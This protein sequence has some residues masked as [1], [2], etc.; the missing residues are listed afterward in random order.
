LSC[1]LQVLGLIFLIRV[2]LCLFK[3]IKTYFLSKNGVYL[4]SKYGARNNSWA[5]VTGSSDGIGKGFAEELARDGFNLILV[6]RTE[7]KLKDL[8]ASIAS[9]FKVEVKFVALDVSSRDQMQQNISKISD[10]IGN[11]SV[12]VL[13]N[14]VGVNTDVPVEFAEMTKDEIDYQIN[15][16]VLFITHLTRALIPTLLNSAN[17]KKTHSAIINV[18]SYT[19]EMP[20]APFLSVYAGTKGYVT[21][22]S[23]ALA[24]ELSS[25]KC[26]VLC[27]SP[28]F[29][30]SAMSG[31][32]KTSF[33]VTSPTQTARDSLGKLGS[34]V[35]VTPSFSHGLQRFVVGFLPDFIVIPK[36]HSQMASTRQRQLKRKSN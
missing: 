23:K 27:I 3:F 33:L 8:S 7:S 21:L 30:A 9:Q 17:S 16:N 4:P 1:V 36:I 5:I 19:A 14:N 11:L 26:D 28:A 15:V 22:W 29:V 12:T 31:I 13:V 25:M 32:K 20:A 24:A 2:G 34:L 35:E 10:A 6:S 18:S